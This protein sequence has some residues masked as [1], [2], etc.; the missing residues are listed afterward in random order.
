[1][2]YIFK[3]LIFNLNYKIDLFKIKFY[4]SLR[5]NWEG[6]NILYTDIFFWKKN[7]VFFF[8]MNM[9]YERSTWIMH[10]P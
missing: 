4:P 6:D 8:F 10:A 3:Y 5:G 1:M 2:Y 9:K 7:I